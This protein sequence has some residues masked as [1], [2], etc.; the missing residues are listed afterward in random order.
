MK[1]KSCVISKLIKLIAILA[2]IGGALYLFKDSVTDILSSVKEK[3][4][5]DD[6]FDDFDDFDDEDMD[7]FDDNE[8]FEDKSDR[9]YVS[10]NITDDTE[11][12]DS[13]DL[14]DP[15]DFGDDDETENA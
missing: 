8:V 5:S 15:E 9:E 4:A 12:E 11:K 14:E 1:K 3:F 6:D 13:K 7:D 2:S 10:I